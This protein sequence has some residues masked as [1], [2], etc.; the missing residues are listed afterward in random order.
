MRND[1]PYFTLKFSVCRLSPDGENDSEPHAVGRDPR[2]P[3][4]EYLPGGHP[5]P[6]RAAS[7]DSVPRRD[8]SK[9]STEA[10]ASAATSRASIPRITI[11]S[12][13]QYGMWRAGL[14]V[15]DRPRRDLPG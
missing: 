13:C 11:N 7:N 14:S 3:P 6:G 12:I 15:G 8:H 2:I 4:E 5:P 1:T 10:Q 9:V